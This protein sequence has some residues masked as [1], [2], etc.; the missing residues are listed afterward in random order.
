[1]TAVP[2]SMPR[3]A[4]RHPRWSGRIWWAR[5]AV[6]ILAAGAGAGPLG[7]AAPG[8]AA[9]CGPVSE[10]Q[11]AERPWPLQ[12]L[13][14]DRVWPITRGGAVI[15]AVID[16]GVSDQ[17]PILA[18]RLVPGKDF[19]DPSGDGTCDEDG[20]GTMIA[21]I[22]AG[23]PSQS[24]GFHGVA[25][26]ARIMPIRVLLDRERTTDEEDPL[27][28][29]EAI[30]YAADNGAEV[31]NLSLTTQPVPEL[32]AAVNYAL[33]K[34][35][36]LVAAAGNEGGSGQDVRAYPAAYDGVIAVAGVDQNG[37]HV[38]TS[39]QGDYVDI[40]APGLW[41]EGPAPQGG[42]YVVQP[43]GGT[44][45]AAGYVSGVAA[46]VRASNRDL[47][48]AQVASR[49]TRT[50][51]RPAHGWDDAVGAG[52]V[53]PYWAVLS[54]AGSPDEAPAAPARIVLRPTAPEPERAVRIAA[55]WTA[56]LAVVLSALVLGGVTVVRSGRR[57]GWRPGRPSAD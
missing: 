16:S 19:V 9:A 25:P 48:A 1:M 23:A 56:A 18:S 42:G 49:I 8:Y 11:L 12:R 24:S 34:D 33:D 29:A 35:V 41:I 30:R 43:D 47:T 26:S 21:G 4:I 17:H 46:L 28:I 3:S 20:H 45:F 22:I 55:A 51:D 57:R 39:T 27:R 5:L 40:A 53:N 14:P 38:A 50:A 36:V 54:L 6:V 15:V 44:S 52:V 31:I 13:R 32:E 37:D 10:S 2:I 7:L